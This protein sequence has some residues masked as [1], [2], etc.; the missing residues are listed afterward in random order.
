M[1]APPRTSLA[2]TLSAAALAFLAAARA[3]HSS[4]LFW[5]IPEGRSVLHG[6]I[7]NHVP[8]AL[9]DPRWLDHEW[10]FEALAA[11]CYDHG[12]FLALVVLC[13]LAAA[14]APILAYCAARERGYDWASTSFAVLLVCAST[15]ISWA[16]RPQNFVLLAFIALLWIMWRGARPWWA[17]LPVAAV[18]SNLHASGVLA[19]VV[20]LA[21]TAAYAIEAGPR[22][23][24]C[25]SALAAAAAAFAGTFLTPHGIALWTYAL[26]SMGDRN[27][28]HRYITEWL[29]LFNGDVLKAAALWLLVLAVILAATLVQRRDELA[30]ALVG[31]AFLALP[32]LHARFVLFTAAA[33]MPLVARSLRA[34]LGSAP[35]ARE[36][37]LPRAVL[38]LPVL[39][40]AAGVWIAASSPGLGREPVYADARTLL[41]RH[42]VSGTIFAEYT[43]AAYLAAFSALPVRVMIDSHGDPFDARA[44]DDEYVLEHA[45]P[46]WD[47]VLRRRGI[48]QVVLPV[49]HPLALALALSPR[50]TTLDRT[51]HARLFVTRR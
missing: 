18:W 5:Q 41:V 32:V 23:A 9:G 16:E 15:S 48:E 28:S 2:F 11:W 36:A 1:T 25:R 13:A 42:H 31:V 21:F 8:W 14:A 44:W 35:Q 27:H 50:W 17:A 29:P 47:A 34:I 6:V 19:P 22:D 26:D 3:P 20:G 49:Q 51:A 43:A 38:A 4:D 12:A 24:R 46:L 37:A 7:P 10:L 30:G 39:G 40:I 33:A 45:L